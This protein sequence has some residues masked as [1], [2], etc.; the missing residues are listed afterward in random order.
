MNDS[1]ARAILSHRTFFIL[2]ML[3][4]V[5]VSS[6]GM[7]FLSLTVDYREYFP[8]DD[9]QL[10]AYNKIQADYSNNEIGRAHV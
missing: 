10:I 2:L 9:P 5:V 4:I 8:S 3:A 6:Y 1:S 7:R